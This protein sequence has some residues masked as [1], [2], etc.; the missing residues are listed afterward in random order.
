MAKDCAGEGLRG[1]WGAEALWL[2]CGAVGGSQGPSEEVAPRR[3]EACGLRQI[4]PAWEAAGETLPGER[5]KV[6]KALGT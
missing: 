3:G 4:F 5:G 6:Q 1:P 2:R